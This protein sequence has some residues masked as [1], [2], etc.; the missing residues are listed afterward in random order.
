MG[1]MINR[2]R[3]CG[4]KSLPY[5]AEIEYLESTG[6]QWIDT[7]IVPNFSTEVHFKGGVTQYIANTTL[8]GARTGTSS[9]NRFFP[10]ACQG[11][12]E[13]Y[14]ITFGN[15]DYDTGINIDY[16]NYITVLFNETN[17]HRLYVN[18]NYKRAYQTGN[19][20]EQQ[21]NLLLFGTTGYQGNLY[22]SVGR[23][24]F[25]RIKQNGN[26]IRDFIPVRVGQVGYMYDRVSKQLFGNSGTGSF[27]L[28]PDIL[29]SGCTQVEY[30]E[31]T[32]TQYIETEIS[33]TVNTEVYI[34]LTM[35]SFDENSIM[36][37]ARTGTTNDNRFFPFA[38]S[39][40]G[41]I[42]CTYGISQYF[43]DITYGTVYEV[44][45]NETET[46]K[47]Y[48]DGTELGVLSGYTKLNNNIFL[49]YGVSGYGVKYNAKGKI[50][51]CV[52][53]ENGIKVRD[54]VPVRVGQVGYMYDRVTKQLFG[55]S[56]TGD[57]ILGAD[58]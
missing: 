41:V 1:M 31:S 49:L 56:G 36:C 30:L 15:D 3:V 58:K 48:I 38:H 7:E 32:G 2:R 14:R 42:R 43:K 29:P 37:G 13:R 21:N 12:A 4:G 50:Y 33:P 8:L 11:A 39:I 23:L 26:L 5:D 35:D 6:T 17:T 10:L 19:I 57:F 28:G 55:N 47:C 40:N 45:F 24:C 25:V 44:L 16:N 9:A 52:I 53:K 22:N 34:K 18:G 27:I 54:F 46:H 20:V 51:E